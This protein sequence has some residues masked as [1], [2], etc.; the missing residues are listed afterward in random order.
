MLEYLAKHFTNIVNVLILWVLAIFCLFGGWYGSHHGDSEIRT[1]GYHLMYS[2]F[3]VGAMVITAIDS[4][5]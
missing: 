5:R 2:I 4:K 3:M 1:I